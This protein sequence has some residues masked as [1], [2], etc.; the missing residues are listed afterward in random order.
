VLFEILKKNRS[1]KENI[2]LARKTNIHIDVLQR[3]KGIRDKVMMSTFL[4]F[5]NKEQKP[6]REKQ[7]V[8]CFL[9]QTHT[10]LN[11]SKVIVIFFPKI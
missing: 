9:N 8:V 4:F 10:Q 3:E 7:H 11:Y 5:L 6:E 1:R 2:N